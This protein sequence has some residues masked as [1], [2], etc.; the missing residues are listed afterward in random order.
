M[1]LEFLQRRIQIGLERIVERLLLLDRR[2]HA[3]VTRAHELDELVLRGADV[4]HRDFV[5]EAVDAGVED[6]DLLLDRQRRVLFLLQ[7]FDE[8]RAAIELVLRGL[9]EVAAAELR[10]RRQLAELREVETQRAGHLAHRLDLRRA[11]DARH[12]VADVDRRADAL[13]EEVRLQEDLAVGDRDDVGRDVRRQVAR[14]RF[15]D[16]QAR[17]A[18][19]R[20][21]CRSASP[22]SPAD[23]SA[24]R[25]RRRDTPRGRADGAAAARFRDTTARASRG[26]RKSAARDGRESRKYSPIAVAE[27]G[28]M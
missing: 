22:L 10:E 3:A 20:P 2:Q 7:H 27:Y 6:R 9:V 25:R 18:S 13:V 24:D 14:L 16:R 28:L 19:R 21:S 1:L 8:P 5:E 17:S 4:G 11:A 23:A 15:D 26:R 12:R